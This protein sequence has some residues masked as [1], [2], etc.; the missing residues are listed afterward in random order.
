MII[1]ILVIIIITIASEKLKL[2]LFRE[3][4]SNSVICSTYL[5]YVMHLI[6]EKYET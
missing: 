5:K 1:I 6:Y 2:R 4:L 3:T